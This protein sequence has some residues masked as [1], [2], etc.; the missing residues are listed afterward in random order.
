MKCA[1]CGKAVIRTGTKQTRCAECQAAYKKAHDKEMYA[2]KKAARPPEASM[3]ICPDCGR[4]VPKTGWRQ[5]RCIECRNKRRAEQ[6]EARRR[7]AEERERRE[8]A[9]EN[10]PGHRIALVNAEARKLGLTYGRYVALI[11]GGTLNDYLREW[12]RYII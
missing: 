8:R 1:D 11:M 2:K 10:D 9:R 6:E 7:A 4:T 12:T 5:V 3:L